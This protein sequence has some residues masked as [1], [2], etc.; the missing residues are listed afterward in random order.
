[1]PECAKNLMPASPFIKKGCTIVL[2]DF[3][4]VLLSAKDGTPILSGQEINAGSTSTNA[5]R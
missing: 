5:K 2:N 4:K 3:D 1:M